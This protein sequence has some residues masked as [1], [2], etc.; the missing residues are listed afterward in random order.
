MLVSRPRAHPV[1][2]IPTS[3]SSPKGEQRAVNPA[4]TRNP[5]RASFSFTI[6]VRDLLWTGPMLTSRA[7]NVTRQ[8][9]GM[10]NQWSATSLWELPAKTVTKT[11]LHET[12]HWY[13]SKSAAPATENGSA[14]RVSG[15]NRRGAGFTSWPPRLAMHRLPRRRVLDAAESRPQVR[16]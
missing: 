11:N 4:I 6:P 10:A 1:T 15:G 2:R 9:A 5:G 8:K 7:R 3:A 13:P 12:T 14:H 16:S